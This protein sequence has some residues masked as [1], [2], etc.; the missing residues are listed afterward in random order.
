[1]TAI[2]LAWLGSVTAIQDRSLRKR[3]KFLVEDK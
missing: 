1:M 2:F 3:S